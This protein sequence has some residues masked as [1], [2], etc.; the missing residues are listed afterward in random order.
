M[1]I[2]II[3]EYI[4]RLV[5]IRH[6]NCFILDMSTKNQKEGRENEKNILRVLVNRQQLQW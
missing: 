1:A 3:K 5:K 4:F 6:N 2:E